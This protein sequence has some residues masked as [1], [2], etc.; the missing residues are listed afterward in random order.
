MGDHNIAMAYFE[1]NQA[2]ALD[3]NKTVLDTIADEVHNWTDTQIRTLLGQFLFSDDTVFKDVETISGGEKARLAIAKLLTSPANFL[4][5]DEPTNHL[6]IGAREAL[7]EALN[8]FQGAV[9]LITH[10]AHLAAA[11]ADRLWL[12]NKGAAA[13]YDGDLSDYRELV[14]SAN[15]TAPKDSGTKPSI[16]AKEQA[17]KY[18]AEARLAIQPLKKAADAAEARVEKLNNTLARLDEALAEPGLFENN[19]QRATKLSKERSALV[20]AIESAESDWLTALETYEAARS[21]AD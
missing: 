20:N 12:V 17:R 3:K 21:G 8:D 11:V 19:L 15:K 5:L 10:D 2:E 16:N 7:I 14:I 4:L 9:L 18:S 6:D 1:Q 13:P